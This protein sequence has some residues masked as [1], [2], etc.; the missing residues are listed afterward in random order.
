[1][2]VEKSYVVHSKFYSHVETKYLPAGILPVKK[3]FKNDSANFL[4]GKNGRWGDTNHGRLPALLPVSPV[5]GPPTTACIAK[6]LLDQDVSRKIKTFVYL[7]S[8]EGACRKLHF[9]WVHKKL[10]KKKPAYCR[11]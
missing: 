10:I 2:A 4:L 5:G 9:A 6:V 3:L 1:M 11:G 7:S 8:E